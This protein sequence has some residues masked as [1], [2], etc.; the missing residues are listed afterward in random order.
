MLILHCFV[1]ILIIEVVYPDKKVK[2]WL[3]TR[4]FIHRDTDILLASL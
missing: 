2:N 4:R 1:I 3:V